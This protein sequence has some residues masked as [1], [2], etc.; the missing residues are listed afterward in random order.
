MQ[1]SAG[2]HRTKLERACVLY[3]R[4]SGTIR[5]IQHVV[6]M[7]GGHEPADQEIELMARS[8][9]A[10]RG[11]SHESLDALHLDREALKQFAIYRVDPHQKALIPV[12]MQRQTVPRS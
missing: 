9:L 10:K 7:E 4:T 3:D 2:R 6:A 8:S 5:H 1:A 12:R 11:I